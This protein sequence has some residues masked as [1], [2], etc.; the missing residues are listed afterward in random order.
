MGCG[1]EGRENGVSSISVD[2]ITYNIRHALSQRIENEDTTRLAR[3]RADYHAYQEI[4][5]IKNCRDLQANIAVYGY[6]LIYHTTRPGAHKVPIAYLNEF[7]RL[8]DTGT[9]FLCDKLGSEGAGGATN[10]PKSATWA[11]FKDVG[12]GNREVV[13]N[14]HAPA[15]VYVPARSKKHKEC[16]ANLETLAFKLRSQHAAKVFLVGDTNVDFNN[17]RQRKRFDNFFEAGFKAQWEFFPDAPPSHGP[18][19][20]K[21]DWSLSNMIPQEMEVL[22]DY[23]SDHRP[24]RV[25]Y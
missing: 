3:L 4:A 15:S 1:V 17:E 20:S 18:H 22:M 10:V 9:E 8:I 14:W 19:K 24:V 25:R 2:L 13:I 7:K 21:I 11:V 16:V 6:K 23:H 12:T 5:S